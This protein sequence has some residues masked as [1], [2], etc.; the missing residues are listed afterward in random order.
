MAMFGLAGRF[1][2]IV[3]P[4]TDDGATLGEVRLAR[5]LRFYVRGGAQGFVLAT[6]TGEFTTLTLSERK[7]LVEMTVRETQSALPVLVNV[8][9]TS[10]SFSLDLAQ[11]AGRHGARAVVLM[12]PYFG[13]LT[14]TEH[15]EHIRVIANHSSLPII[16]C[17]PESELRE[18]A[19]EGI[20]HLPNVHLAG[21]H[22][23]SRNTHTDW[24]QCQQ[25]AVDPMA[26]VPDSC[27]ADF[28]GR[29]RAAVAKT[30][31]LDHEVEVGPPRMPVQPV[32][33]REIR[34]AA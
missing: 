30:L 5:L 19:L 23:G 34:K 7:Q 4:F 8:S 27:A 28:A 24:F 32:P 6:D 17:D 25:M 26:A 31:L 22:G 11:H 2:P 20:G 18:E 12:P 33:Y 15:M 29:N 1:V 21:P 3:T 10:T 14:Q 9:S 13:R 16:V